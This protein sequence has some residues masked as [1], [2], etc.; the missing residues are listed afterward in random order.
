MNSVN[1]KLLVILLAGMAIGISSFGSTTKPGH[2]D[3]ALSSADDEIDDGGERTAAPSGD[4]DQLVEQAR[5]ANQMANTETLAIVDDGKNVVTAN[6]TKDTNG[7][8]SKIIANEGTEHAKEIVVHAKDERSLPGAIKR[9]QETVLKRSKTAKERQAQKKKEQ[10][11]IDKKVANCELDTDRK[12][13]IEDTDT[14]GKHA[15]FQDRMRDMSTKEK[16]AYMAKLVKP[17]VDKEAAPYFQ[18]LNGQDP[19]GAN[20]TVAKANLVELQQ[21]LAHYGLAA[22]FANDLNAGISLATLRSQPN[23]QALQQ[24]LMQTR[25]AQIIAMNPNMPVAQKTAMQQ[26]IQAAMTQQSFNTIGN[27]LGQRS[28]LVQGLSGVTNPLLAQAMSNEINTLG[29][30]AQ[31]LTSSNSAISKAYSGLIN[32]NLN[33]GSAMN[34]INSTDTWG[35]NG[36]MSGS[37][38]NMAYGADGVS[39]FNP[40]SIWSDS[41]NALTNPSFLSTTTL[42]K[43]ANA[44][45]KPL[46]QTA[47]NVMTLPR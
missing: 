47:L 14:E 37:A 44:N 32:P 18:A 36:L 26:Q 1:Q 20:A 19:N 8:T 38:L 27:E 21:S 41:N 23:T 13:E 31:R 2:A 22:P 6:V 15:C 7:F 46:Q 40:N 9:G 35:L 34:I 30:D 25:A 39:S 45:V 11:E 43:A 29:T 42:P 12:T 3:L 17:Y 10:K 33:T 4:I 24:N 28:A 5:A 16:K